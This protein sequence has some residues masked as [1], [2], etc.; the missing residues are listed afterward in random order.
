MQE[1]ALEDADI[2]FIRFSMDAGCRLL[3]CGSRTGRVF[4]W[5]V[6]TVSPHPKWRVKRPL[7]K[8][9]T[10]RCCCGTVHWRHICRTFWH[11]ALDKV[12]D[13]ASAHLK[14]CF[15]HHRLQDVFRKWRIASAGA[16]DSPVT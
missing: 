2:W 4:M 8:D 14:G 10:V 13:L 15:M 1:L 6:D 12:P 7:G 16:A 11:R 3:A 9:N 5:D